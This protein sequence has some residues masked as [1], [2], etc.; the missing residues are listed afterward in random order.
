MSEAREDLHGMATGRVKWFNDAK[1]FG[2][3]ERGDGTQVFVH[4]SAIARGGAGATSAAAASRKTLREGQ[5]VEFDLYESTK[6]LEARNVAS[7]L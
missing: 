6:G 2:F 7:K 1:G 5:E 4:Y 3:I